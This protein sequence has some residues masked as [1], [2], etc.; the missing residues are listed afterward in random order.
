VFLKHPNYI[1]LNVIIHTKIVHL[2]NALFTLY[3]SFYLFIMYI[4]RHR[5]T[6]PMPKKICQVYSVEQ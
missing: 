4:Q 3:S 5:Y 2:L 6:V 1:Q